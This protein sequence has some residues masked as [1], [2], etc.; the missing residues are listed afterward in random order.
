MAEPKVVSHSAPDA[1]MML[2]GIVLDKLNSEIESIWFKFKLFMSGNFALFAAF[3]FIMSSAGF[4]QQFTRLCLVGV[5]VIG[6]LFCIWGRETLDRAWAWHDEFRV[7]L[8][9]IEA[10][11]P[12]LDH[13]PRTY[14]THTKVAVA[15][16][17][18]QQSFLI[19]LAF[20]WVVLALGAL[21]LPIIR[22][23]VPELPPLGVHA[24]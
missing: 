9:K 2:Y 18:R 16:I 10:G 5:A 3:A 15:S 21:T 17:W 6:C 4:P 8:A 11:F 12:A 23:D 22:A 1:H 24:K 19:L 20:T 13:W 7:S 14:L